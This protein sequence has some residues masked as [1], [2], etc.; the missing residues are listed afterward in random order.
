MKGGEQNKKI[1]ALLSVLAQLIKNGR[2]TIL[3]GLALVLGK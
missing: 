2:N 1:D 3:S